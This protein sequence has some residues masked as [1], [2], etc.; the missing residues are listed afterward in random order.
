[1]K[2]VACIGSITVD[3]IV[4]PADEIPSPETLKAVENVDM[5]V[6]GCAS[7]AAIDLAKIGVP[8]ELICTVGNDPFGEYI[9]S[10][11][12]KNGV[13]TEGVR[14]NPASSTT[15]SVVCV[16]KTGERSFLYKP[17]STADFSLSDV[18]TDIIDKCDI[19]FVAG[20]F[21]LRDFDGKPCA[22]FMKKLSP[23]VNLLL[24]IRRGILMM[25]G[26][27]KSKK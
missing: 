19:V 2:T 16:S 23:K 3:I 10:V 11:C 5:Y 17:G 4:K 13:G 20:A 25:F 27:L 14:I 21:L 9:K 15:G 18:C 12:E 8:C 1:M 7:N 22:E 26:Y 24:W 6:G